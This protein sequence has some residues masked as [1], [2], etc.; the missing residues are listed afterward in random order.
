LSIKACDDL[1]GKRGIT[2]FPFASIHITGGTMTPLHMYDID[3][4]TATGQV[5]LL[6][7]FYH[8]GEFL[9]IFWVTDVVIP[10]TV[11]VMEKSCEEHAMLFVRYVRIA[12]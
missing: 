9:F 2:F 12:F 10:E 6:V 8:F 1:E 11:N 3:G 5:T 7:W 4:S